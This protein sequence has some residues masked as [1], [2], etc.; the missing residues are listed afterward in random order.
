MVQWLGAECPYVQ[1]E[2]L[3]VPMTANM[4]PKYMPLALELLNN[5]S[6]FSF[7]DV[8]NFDE[9]MI[10]V[11]NQN[12]EWGTQIQ[13]GEL[14]RYQVKAKNSNVYDATVVI[15]DATGLPIFNMQTDVFGFTPQVSL[16]SDFLLDRNWNH[17]VGDLNY[18]IPGTSPLKPVTL[19]TLVQMV[20]IMMVIQLLTKPIQIA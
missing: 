2:C 17:V 7:A 12:T 3:N 10:H 6:V 1:N 19:R 5:A 13:K 4:P 15:K 18:V 14:V 20:S 9:T 8:Q 16:P 11:Q